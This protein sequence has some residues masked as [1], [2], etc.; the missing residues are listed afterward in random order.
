QMAVV[1]TM[2]QPIPPDAPLD[3]RIAAMCAQRAHVFEEVAPVRK[4]AQLQ[5][6][7]SPGLSSLLTRVR[8]AS[9]NGLADLFAHELRTIPARKRRLR[10]A[11]LDALLNAESWD[12]MRTVHGLSFAEAR[13]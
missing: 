7:T 8:E 6:P 3:Q 12:V 11:S 10:L 9:R 5:A 13:D 4:A 2:V 1:A